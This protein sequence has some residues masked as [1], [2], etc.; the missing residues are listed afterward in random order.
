MV[1]VEDNIYALPVWQ[2]APPSRYWKIKMISRQRY[3]SKN[4]GNLILGKH[5]QMQEMST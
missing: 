5:L 1:T 2:V 3:Q 4:H